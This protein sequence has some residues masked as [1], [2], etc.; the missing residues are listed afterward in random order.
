MHIFSAIRQTTSEKRKT[1]MFAANIVYLN[2]SSNQCI[3]VVVLLLLSYERR[4]YLGVLAVSGLCCYVA[5][6]ILQQSGYKFKI[7][8]RELECMG[9]WELNC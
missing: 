6:V 5:W 3:F 9:L 8:Y 2:H 4:A 7:N 1:P